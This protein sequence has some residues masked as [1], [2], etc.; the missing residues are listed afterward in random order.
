MADPSLSFSSEQYWI[1]TAQVYK[2]AYY[3][4]LTTY[5]LSY[6]SSHSNRKSKDS[7]MHST[8]SWPSSLPAPPE[9]PPCNPHGW[10]QWL[11]AAELSYP[12]KQKKRIVKN[13]NHSHFNCPTITPTYCISEPKL[14]ENHCFQCDWWKMYKNNGPFCTTNQF[15]HFTITLLQLFNEWGLCYQM[16]NEIPIVFIF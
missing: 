12:T 10:V 6:T 5:T 15:Y 8:A 9:C 13:Y 14:I 16:M 7:I 3:R 2:C 11:H 4:C 1:Q